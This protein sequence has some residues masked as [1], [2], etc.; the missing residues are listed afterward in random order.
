MAESSKRR[1]SRSCRASV[2][3]LQ[4]HRACLIVPPRK[5]CHTTTC[6]HWFFALTKKPLPKER[7]GVRGQGGGWGSGG[8][9]CGWLNGFEGRATGIK[10]NRRTNAVD[11]VINYIGSPSTIDL[12]GV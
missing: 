12:Q 8:G 11:H 1:T 10:E 5:C 7:G 2:L 6:C 9:G 4:C 3:A